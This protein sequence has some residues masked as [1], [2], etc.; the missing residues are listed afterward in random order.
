MKNII[1][2]ALSIC[3]LVVTSCNTATVNPTAAGTW[4]FKSNTY[5]ASQAFYILGALDAYTGNSSPT[6]SISF[7]FSDTFP[8][9][10]SYTVTNSQ[11][12]PPAAGQVYVQLT[13]TSLYNAYVISGSTHPQVT[14]TVSAANKVTVYLPPVWVTNVNT[15]PA[16][17][18]G[19]LYVG[20]PSYTDSSLVTGT[21]IQTK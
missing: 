16:T 13:D 11:A 17:P 2:I 19:Q 9:L 18:N 14:V 6:G 5:N 12:F 10:G 21:I 7:Y 1:A 8:R 3:L 20:F 4:T 15:T